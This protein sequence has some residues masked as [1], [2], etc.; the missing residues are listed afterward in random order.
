MNTEQ[1]GQV[2]KAEY[3]SQK[4]D[5]ASECLKLMFVIKAI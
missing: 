4:V 3:L 2:V 1:Q 5:C